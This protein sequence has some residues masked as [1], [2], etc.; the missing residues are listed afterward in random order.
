LVLAMSVPVPT[1]PAALAGFDYA[2]PAPASRP[3]R[4]IGTGAW[5]HVRG[6]PGDSLVVLGRHARFWGTAPGFDT[7]R[8]VALGDDFDTRALLRAG[9]IDWTG[10]IG[11]DEALMLAADRGVSYRAAWPY[12]IS[13][14]DVDPEHPVLRDVA[15]RRAL[16]VAMSREMLAAGHGSQRYA[17]ARRLLS[18]AMLGGDTTTVGSWPTL[19]EARALL[20]RAWRGQ[21]PLRFYMP[22]EDLLAVEDTTTGDRAAI[23][24]FWRSAGVP[25]VFV[26]GDSS[27][28]V[29]DPIRHG[30]A[31]ARFYRA[32]GTSLS[33]R[34]L[35]GL[36][37]HSI[38]PS[39]RVAGRAPPSERDTVLRRL[40]AASEL[41]ADSVAEARLVRAIERRLLET[42]PRLPLFWEPTPVACSARLS[43]C[44]GALTPRFDGVTRR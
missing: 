5:R 4:P 31:D 29:Y 28:V 6:D 11:D 20:A 40:F 32:I 15:V 1:L 23:V 27:G 41:T 26:R 18:P 30:V 34:T 33:A 16:V 10:D 9:R 21:R 24:R 43:R 3:D 37:A 19:P 2:V 38:T 25:V 42:V 35:V 17:A 22:P 12:A 13:Y 7:L 36:L 8:L 44:P 39:A 14:I